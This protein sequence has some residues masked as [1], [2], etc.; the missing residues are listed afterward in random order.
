[1]LAEK[2]GFGQWAECDRTNDGLEILSRS[3][4]VGASAMFLPLK[5]DE[6]LC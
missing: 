5:I 6:T 1:M 4:V 2:D 3:G